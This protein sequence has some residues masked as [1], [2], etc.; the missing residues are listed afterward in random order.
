MTQSA[1]SLSNTIFKKYPMNNLKFL[2]LCL[3]CLVACIR[4]S[5]QPKASFNSF[6]NSRKPTLFSQ[7][8]E[9][10]AI[11]TQ[12]LEALFNGSSDL[13][14][15]S[16]DRKSF[17]FSGKLIP[18]ASKY[19]SK[20]RTLIIRSSNFSGATLTLSSSTL[21]DGTVEYSGRI[22]SFKHGDLL[23]IQKEENEYF[24]IKKNFRDLIAE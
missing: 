2:G 16:S 8:P 19:D 10:I 17:T 13:S 22:I 4:V 20:I 3:V 7:L 12:D 18:S 14:I 11:N 24:L 23:V 15:Q 21:P 1:A 9:R 6:D 5:A